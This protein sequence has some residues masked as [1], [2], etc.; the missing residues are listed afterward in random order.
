MGGE[1][2]KNSN[3]VNFIVEWNNKKCHFY[4]SQ[5]SLD[6]IINLIV[7]PFFAQIFC[8]TCNIAC[9]GIGLGGLTFGIVTMKNIIV[10]FH[11]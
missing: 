2:L 3:G 1:A 4:N 8:C 11:V 10:K 6:I 5:P 9:N 7:C